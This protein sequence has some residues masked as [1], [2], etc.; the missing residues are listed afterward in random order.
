MLI[1]GNG[2]GYVQLFVRSLRN[3]DVDIR[4]LRDPEL[5]LG[6]VYDLRFDVRI[7]CC[8]FFCLCFHDLF[9]P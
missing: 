7:L 9:S 6:A 4:A 3:T 2:L 5:A 8:F 1:N